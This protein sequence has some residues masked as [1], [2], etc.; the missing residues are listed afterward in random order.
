MHRFAAGTVAAVLLGTLGLTPLAPTAEAAPED[1]IAGGRVFE[2]NDGNG[3]FDDD[4]SDGYRERGIGNVT[5]TVTDALGRSATTT[6]QRTQTWQPGDPPDSP[7]FPN[8]PA[9]PNVTPGQW[10]WEAEGTWS[11]TE[12]E[13]TEQTGEVPFVKEGET[14]AQL[15]VTYSDAPARYESWFA[16]D[17]AQNGSSVQFAQSGDQEIDYALLRP[18]DH[19]PEPLDVITSIQSAG[20][21]QHPSVVDAP[22]LRST[23]WTTSQA[24]HAYQDLNKNDAYDEGV[25]N[26]APTNPDGEEYRWYDDLNQDGFWDEDEPGSDVAFIDENGNGYWD[27]GPWSQMNVYGGLEPTGPTV[28][29]EP[30]T[31]RSVRVVYPGGECWHGP[32]TVTERLTDPQ[33]VPDDPN[34]A[35]DESTNPRPGAY[36]V[37]NFQLPEWCPGNPGSV[38][39]VFVPGGAYDGEPQ[40]RQARTVELTEPEE[41]RDIATYG[42]VGSVWGA[43]YEQSSNSYLVSAVYKRISGLA[44]HRW[45]GSTERA[46]GGIF[47]IPEVLDPGTGKI[48]EGIGPS[49]DTEPWFSLTDLGIDVGSVPS[50]A[51][52][53]LAG[54]TEELADS[55]AFANA[56]KVGIG[57]IDTWTDGTTTYL[58]VMNLA[59]RNLYRIDISPSNP[60]SPSYDPDFVPTAGDVLQIPL[61]LSESERPWAVEVWNDEV[62]VGWSD[63]GSEPGHC[64]TLSRR[65]SEPPDWTECD[66]TET[67]HAYAGRVALD[68][69]AVTT[70]MDIDQGYPRGNPI[71]NW[72]DQGDRYAQENPQVRRW[73]TWSDVWTWDSAD[74]DGNGFPDGSVGFS[75]R[76]GSGWSSGHYVQAYPQAVVS[77]LSFDSAGFLSIGMMD[78]TALQAGNIQRAADSDDPGG[79][80]PNLYFEGVSSGDTTLA[81]WNANQGRYVHEFEGRSTAVGLDGASSQRFDSTPEHHN[82]GPGGREFYDDDQALDASARGSG[83]ALN[84]EEVGLGAVLGLPG[85][86]ELAM[87]AFD[88]LVNIRVQGLMWLGVEDGAPTRAV[89]LT[90]DP[91]HA[92]H[93]DYS[94]QKGGGLGDLDALAVPPPVEIGN[95]VSFDAD[96]DG[97][98][99]ADEPGIPGVTVEL[100]DSAGEVIGTQQTAEDGTYYFTSREENADHYAP[101]EHG[102]DYTVRFVKPED[103]QL[104]VDLWGTRVTAPWS[105]VPFTEMQEPEGEN[106]HG[107]NDNADGVATRQQVTPALEPD[108]PV[109]PDR[110]DSNPDT[111]NGEYTFTLGGSGRNEHSIDAAYV[112][113]APLQVEKLIDPEGGA[114]APGMTF[115][116]TLNT[117]DFRGLAVGPDDPDPDAAFTFEDLAAYEQ[118]ADLVTDADPNGIADGV[119]TVRIGEDGT[120]PPATAWFPLGSTVE[121]TEVASDA[122]EEVTYTPTGPIE[123][124]DGSAEA[125]PVRVQVTNRL[126]AGTFSVTKTVT[127]EAAGQ[128]PDGTSFTAQYSVDGGETWVDLVVPYDAD[129]DG[130]PAPAV[131][132]TLPVGTEVLLCEIDLPPPPA[133]VAWGEPTI[134]GEGVTF[135]PETGCATF[136]VTE[137]ET[138]VQLTLEN[139]ANPAP[140]DWEVSKTVAGGAAGDVPPGT[141]FVVEWTTTPDDPDSWQTLEVPY[142]ETVS[143]PGDLPAGTEVTVREGPMPDVPNV[144]WGTPVFTVGSGEPQPGP[145]TFTVG[146]GATVSLGMENTAEPDPGTF[147][148]QKAI[149]GGAAGVAGAADPTFAFEYSTDGGE[150]WTQLDVPLGEIVSPSEEFPIGTE[151]LIREVEPLPEVPGV[152]WGDPQ[153]FVDGEP[154]DSPATITIGG[155]DEPSPAIVM[156]NTAE[157]APGEFTVTKTLQGPAAGDVPPGTEFTVQYTVDGGEPV[158]ISVPVGESVTIDDVPAG[159][160]VTVTEVSLPDIPGIVWG[161][162][163]LSVDGVPQEGDSVTFTVGADTGVSVGVTNTA[164]YAPGNF[165]VEKVLEGEAADE[166]PD[167]T[168][169]VLEYSVD[170]GETWNPLTVPLGQLVTSGE[171]PAGTEVLLR[172]GPLPDVPGVEWGTPVVSP[173]S[174]TVGAGTTA[175]ITMTNTANDAPGEFTVAK[176]LDGEAAGDVPL[177]AGFTVEY[178]IDGGETWETLTVGA[179]GVPVSSGEIPA[180]TEVLLRETDQRPDVPGVQWGE[181]TLTID[182][183]PVDGDTAS[184]TIGPDTV[185]ELVATNTAEYQPGNFTVEKLLEGNGAGDVPEGTEFTIEYT[186]DG[187]EPQTATMT[188]GEPWTSPD[189]PAGSEVTVTEVNL[190]DVEGV[191]WGEPAL[192][193]DGQA[194]EAPAT[195]TVGAGTTVGVQVTNTA[196]EAPGNFTVAKSVTG[197][198]AGDVPGDA[199]FVVEYSIDGGETWEELR[200]TADGT[201]VTSPDIPAG[202]QVMVRET[203]ARPDVPGVTWGEVRLSVDGMPINGTTATFT[204]DADTTVE[205]VVTNPA[206]QSPGTFTVAKAVDGEAAGEVPGDAEFTLEYSTD[207]G[208][209]W[210][211]LTVRADGTPVTA[212]QLP[213]G[214]EVLV[215]ETD[216]RPDVPGVEWGEVS[217]TVDGEPVDG[218][219][220]SFTVGAGTTVE[221]VVTN[222]AQPAPGGFE[223]VKELT[224]DAAGLVPP[225]TEFTVEY[226]TDGGQT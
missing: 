220:A 160:E 85:A 139:V 208:E 191:T 106:P 132:P 90:D 13:F 72:G 189:L 51:D 86:T 9:D 35:V 184:F 42:E 26:L 8:D 60:A 223:I 169:F 123:L 78:R 30:Q 145:V 2:D 91:G 176:A 201:P 133:G 212:P 113:Y 12:G 226:S 210:N 65:E 59:D 93:P 140:G 111:E 119:L 107:P 33:T 161:D 76:E 192:T 217:L 154:V 193:V 156:L 198:A 1:V 136:T 152:V 143:P 29:V 179:D 84:H 62:Y 196:E 151:V 183:E 207:G 115:D 104:E 128:V 16:V 190:P 83:G 173:E 148:V 167:G 58:Y 144:V 95:R 79:T 187:G 28:T 4:A 89:E 22:A 129:G 64:A 81:G 94:F 221:V 69:G 117:Q 49:G 180:G 3:E 172:E 205:I 37:E 127:G 15:R 55:D 67:L 45:G 14:T 82:S 153:L 11:M 92:E 110:T 147:S 166:V 40:F 71:S 54:P 97:Q 32:L 109:D 120:V 137:G 135:D 222:T 6:T 77:S 218:D 114:G 25:D 21:P 203:V 185:V 63:T 131:S 36:V 200:V 68:G 66:S 48:A 38:S 39:G 52:R 159:A 126:T 122:V 202:T 46:L 124:V 168:E 44:E 214:T 138:G 194:V 150:T 27:Q 164:R 186:V 7:Q 56:A 175:E 108:P 17:R 171:F 178:S 96:Q 100:V 103:G 118:N 19:R 20:D 209:T 177:S 211:P 174:L 105:D 23:D 204:V 112:A 130:A 43:A 50:N 155:A 73:N 195:F 70:V 74:A 182:G 162:P 61:G 125:T 197:G 98:Q 157:P 134:S 34:T 224:G 188:V 170:G 165:S 225:E 5:V 216:D 213:A 99:S 53:G 88:P 215:R 163:I 31:F 181:V 57:G 199:T 10:V 24:V 141:T 206:E 158:E 142:G 121:V 146:A 47:R 18:E 41:P 87:T 75:T 149:I 101:M 102:Q 116:L 219:T 80:P